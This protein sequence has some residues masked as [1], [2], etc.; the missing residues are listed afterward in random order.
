MQKLE[1]KPFDPAGFDYEA[2]KCADI[3][4]VGC[5]YQ[6]YGLAMPA[7]EASAERYVVVGYSG[8]SGLIQTGGLM[9]WAQA[10]D[11]VRDEIAEQLAD[12]GLP[13]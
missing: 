10:M 8:G 2:F 12:E 4:G 9:T 6:I 5:E 11:L 13:V 7:A 1:R 3:S